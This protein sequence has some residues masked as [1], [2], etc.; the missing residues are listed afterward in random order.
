LTLNFGWTRSRSWAWCSA[1]SGISPTSAP[2]VWTTFGR[3]GSQ[4]T[5]IAFLILHHGTAY[6]ETDGEGSGMEFSGGSVWMKPRDVTV[7]RLT[8]RGPAPFIAG[9]ALANYRIPPAKI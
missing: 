2:T 9:M 4:H 5:V 8:R 3:F 7:L 6:I 1:S